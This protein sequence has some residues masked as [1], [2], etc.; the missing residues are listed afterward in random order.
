MTIKRTLLGV[1]LS[2]LALTTYGKNTEADIKKL[3]SDL[4]QKELE[5]SELGKKITEQEEIVSSYG[6]KLMAVYEQAFERKKSN[7]H[8]EE[9][10]QTLTAEERTEICD[11]I[12]KSFDEFLEKLT[13]LSDPSNKERFLVKEFF[14]KEE[15]DICN[16]FDS[17]KFHI[18]KIAF[19]FAILENL[20]EQYEDCLRDFGTIYDQLDALE[21]KNKN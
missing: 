11:S 10:N 4:F 19:E 2:A 7:L 16:S 5:L 21:E 14:N 18:L 15:A 8:K 12:N 3:R 20:V 6:P 1:F 9:A 13:K 17:A